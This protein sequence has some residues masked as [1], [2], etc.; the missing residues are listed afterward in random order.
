M[1]VGLGNP[2]SDYARH[3]HNVGFR[4]VDV[5]ARAHGLAFSRRKKARAYVAEGRIGACPV[6]LAKPQTYMNRS[7]RAVGRLMRDFG[8]SPE[9]LLVVYDDLDLPLGRLRLRAEGGSG[10]HKGMRSIQEVIG[11]QAYPRLRVG[12]DRPPDRIDPADYVLAPFAGD[13]EP[14]LMVVLARAAAAVE[15]WLAEGVVAAMDEFNRPFLP[16][17]GNDL[18]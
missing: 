2:G 12:I 8:L 13:E 7:G 15:C 1:V 16:E 3:R 5:L 10:G 14:L 18:A 17:E 4:V 6:V 9:R 11:T